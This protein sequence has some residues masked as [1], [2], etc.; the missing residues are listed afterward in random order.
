M[1]IFMRTQNIT[2]VTRFAPVVIEKGSHF[3]SKEDQNRLEVFLLSIRED[4]DKIRT[5]YCQTDQ[6]QDLNK[7]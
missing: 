2:L 5:I 4:K 3:L 1:L 7:H 6:H